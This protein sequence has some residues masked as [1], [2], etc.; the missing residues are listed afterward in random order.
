MPI[1]KK[2]DNLSDLVAKASKQ[3]ARVIERK[4]KLST[5]YADESTSKLDLDESVRIQNHALDTL[6]DDGSV[7]SF[8]EAVDGVSPSPKA[9]NIV[10][11]GH[12]HHSS[13]DILS[14]MVFKFIEHDYYIKGRLAFIVFAFYVLAASVS[15]LEG[16]W[17]DGFF[18]VANNIVNVYFLIDGLL[19]LLAFRANILIDKTLQLSMSWFSEIRRIGILDILISA[20]CLYFQKT[21]AGAWLQLLRVLSI[22]IFGIQSITSLDVLMVPI[23]SMF[24]ACLR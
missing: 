1:A 3:R 17:W 23:S 11:L 14:S 8:D 22:A 20:L 7:H 10:D 24:R 13:S 12:S 4:R 2:R 18:S 9:P 19:K 21:Y 5:V 6:D 15:L 16:A